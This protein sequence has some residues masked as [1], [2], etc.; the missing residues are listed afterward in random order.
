MAHEVVGPIRVD[1]HQHTVAARGVRHDVV[2]IALDRFRGDAVELVE[3][4]LPLAAAV[5]FGDGAFH[6]A[7]HA[8]GIEDHAAI[9]VARRAANRLDQRGFAAQEAFLVRVQNGHQPAFGNV[10][11]L[12]QQ[13]DAHQHVIYAK[14]QVAD[15]LD[16]LERLDV[17]M[18]V[19]HAQPCLV[20]ELGEVLGHALG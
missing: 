5:G 6:G 1:L 11:P 20:H 18:H 19:A 3:R 14:A 10:Q 17:R 16:A 7:G 15:Q 2:D 8:V 4:A 12:A 13:V 9:H